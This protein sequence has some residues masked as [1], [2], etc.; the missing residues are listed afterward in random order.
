MSPALLM[1]L[2]RPL[3]ASSFHPS[4]LTR[5][6]AGGPPQLSVACLKKTFWEKTEDGPNQL[7]LGGE[8]FLAWYNPCK[9]LR[10][11]NAKRVSSVVL[12]ACSPSCSINPYGWKDRGARLSLAAFSSEAG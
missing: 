7:Y 4:S 2:H 10:C 9:R 6:V 1:D 12:L 8:N 5:I 11:Q 3:L